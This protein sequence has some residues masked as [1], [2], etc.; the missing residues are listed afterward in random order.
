M[1]SLR[2]KTAIITGASR[3]LGQRV[4]LRLAQHGA[5]VVLVAR[6]ESALKETKE[7][8][9]PSDVRVEAVQADVANPESVERAR[10]AIHAA[11]GVPS[12][13]VNAAGV[14]GPIALIKDTDPAAWIETI[15]VNTIGAYLTCRAFV[16]G[17]IQSG[18]GRIVNFT[19]AAS[20]H[21]PGPANSAYATSKAALNQFTRHLASEIKGT[22]VTANVLHPGDVKTEM[23]RDIETKAQH[24]G[25]AGEAFSQ[26]ANWV[27]QTGGDDPEKA[28]DLVM[29]LMSEEASTINGQFLWIKDGLQTPV[30]SWEMSADLRPWRR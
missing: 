12:I 22:G 13:L 1:H 9:A 6:T 28:A 23:W 29:E 18:W 4:A 7:L 25:A 2:G 20:L 24:L 3:G 10:E 27:R 26:W 15:M 21:V 8:I 14:F 30:A 16:G 19:S 5:S 17:M 11:L